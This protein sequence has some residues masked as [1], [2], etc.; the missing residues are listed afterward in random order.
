MNRTDDGVNGALAECSSK[1]MIVAIRLGRSPRIRDRGVRA[2]IGDVK[3][4]I[5]AASL[6]VALLAVPLALV[7]RAYA[8]GPV[9]CT[10]MCCRMHQAANAM[11]CGHSARSASQSVIGCAAQTGTDY[12]LA[13]PLPPFQL[14]TGVRVA[15]MRVARASTAKRTN[16]T[17]LAGFEFPPFQPPRA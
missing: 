17:D 4:R 14:E 11:K 16:V 12:G 13:S 7:A 1:Q 3:K 2:K 8:G 10:M 9:R 6:I 5:Q 15:G